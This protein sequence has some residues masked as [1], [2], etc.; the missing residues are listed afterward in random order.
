MNWFIPAIND[1]STLKEEINILLA[2]DLCHY[3]PELKWIK[4]LIAKH[5]E[6]EF[7]NFT[8]QRSDVVSYHLLDGY[9]VITLYAAI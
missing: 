7:S 1:E 3:V 9:S 8:S 2:R 5:T 6:H 4:D